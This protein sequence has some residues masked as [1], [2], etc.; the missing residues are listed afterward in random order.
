MK[1]EPKHSG[2]W[3]AVKNSKVIA[4]SKTLKEVSKATA[5]RKDQSSLRFTLIPKGL[6][7]G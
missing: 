2:K 3:V 5:N 4:S 1:F 6:I 7:A